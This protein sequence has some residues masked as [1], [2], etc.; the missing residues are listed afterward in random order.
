MQQHEAPNEQSRTLLS[1]SLGQRLW[2]EVEALPKEER[3]KDLSPQ[4]F[5]EYVLPYV[6]ALSWLRHLSTQES[7][8]T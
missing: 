4:S 2:A 3:P 1:L 8:L 7:A 5:F 6:N